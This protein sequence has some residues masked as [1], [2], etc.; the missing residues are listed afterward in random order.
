MTNSHGGPLHPGETTNSAPCSSGAAANVRTLVETFPLCSHLLGD[1]GLH[2]NDTRT[3]ATFGRCLNMKYEPSY[4]L[5]VAV[6]ITND[7]AATRAPSR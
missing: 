1:C 7:L 5:W 6:T 2:S 3:L 4:G